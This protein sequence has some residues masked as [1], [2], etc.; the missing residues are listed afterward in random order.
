M[1]FWDNEVSHKLYMLILRVKLKFYT[2][3]SL[4]KITKK[5]FEKNHG[6]GLLCN[7]YSSS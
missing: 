6:G 2:M 5:D 7:K 3:E 4:Y 1:G